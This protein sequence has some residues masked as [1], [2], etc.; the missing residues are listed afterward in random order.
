MAM[1]SHSDRAFLVALVAGLTF[2]RRPSPVER[3][4]GIAVKQDAGMALQRDTSAAHGPSFRSSPSFTWVVAS[5]GGGEAQALALDADSQGVVVGGANQ[6]EVGFGQMR[7]QSRSAQ[8]G[9]VARLDSDGRAKFIQP[10]T[11]PG[12]RAVVD[13][14]AAADG[15]AVALLVAHGTNRSDAPL[16]KELYKHQD[17]DREGDDAG[18]LL[19]IGPDGAEIWK[20][21]LWSPLRAGG[22][23]FEKPGIASIAPACDEGVVVVLG[24]LPDGS[25]LQRWDAHGKMMWER[26]IKGGFGSAILA[27]P[28]R[29]SNC[30][31]VTLTGTSSSGLDVSGCKFKEDAP[32]VARL[33]GRGA[34][35]WSW[36][37]P[38]KQR[39]YQVG[40][41]ACVGSRGRTFVML[42]GSDSSDSGPVSM[43][44]V[45][46]DGK[47][48]WVRDVGHADDEITACAALSSGGVAAVMQHRDRDVPFL[49]WFAQPYRFPPAYYDRT[50]FVVLDANGERQAETNI[51]GMFTVGGEL[52]GPTHQE[53]G[54]VV[55]SDDH[56]ILG[57]GVKEG[58][59]WA[60]FVAGLKK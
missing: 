31:E 21:Q 26:S 32:F 3:D 18:L 41:V 47:E 11:G 20:R 34:C 40:S 53:R 43:T 22:T 14:L 50:H 17:V 27:H 28:L 10:I 23:A 1:P 16:Q 39:G 58:S 44:A 60:M 2:C 19:R 13:V 38:P 4:S 52:L 35:L 33:D 56:L 59:L 42:R 30:D 29:P 46:G 24:A 55:G 7:A 48:L 5:E 45:E 49:H 37:P 12:R 8:D 9:F 15:G 51:D 57:G 36:H 25:R 54:V 6:G